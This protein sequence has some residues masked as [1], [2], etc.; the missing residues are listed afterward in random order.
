MSWHQL[1]SKPRKLK[2][3]Q[4]AVSQ[5]FDMTAI[6]Y[7]T[8]LLVALTF[9]QKG[10]MGILFMV[11]ELSVLGLGLGLTKEVLLQMMFLKP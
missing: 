11:Q 10:Q 2:K 8:A 3:L 5:S 1:D 6:T 9:S 4:M 7:L